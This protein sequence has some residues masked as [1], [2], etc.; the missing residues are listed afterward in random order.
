MHEKLL[1]TVTNLGNPNVL[2]V[3][4]FM[5]DVYIYGDALRI[6]PEAPVPVLKVKETSYSLGGAGSVVNDLSVLGANA[7]CLGVLGNDEHGKKLLELLNKTRSDIEGL[8]PI[9]D[10]PT[11]TKQRLVGLAQ[12]RHKQQLMRMDHEL[13]EP[14]KEKEYKQLMAVYEKKVQET[15]IVCLQDYNKGIFTKEICGKMISIAKKYKKRVLVDPSLTSDYSKYVGASLLTP[16]RQETSNTAGFEI[17]SEEDARKA[18]RELTKELQLEG[19]IITL[20]K[21]GAYLKIGE[22]EELVPTRERT[23]YDVTGAGDMVL[24][25]LAMMLASG[26]DHKTAVQI[27]NI[28]GGIEVEKFGVATVTVDEIINEIVSEY[29]GKYGKV[30]DIETLKDTIQW[31]RKKGDKIVFTNGCFD[32]LHRG[33]VEYLNFCKKQGDIVVLGLNSDSSV[34]QLKGADRPINN[35]DDRAAVLASLEAIDYITIFDDLDPY[36]TIKEVQPDYLV[37]GEDWRHKGVIGRDIVEARGGKVI[38][39][40]LVEGKSTTGTINKMKEMD[41]NK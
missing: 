9:K 17:K 10:R 38:L 4:D 28:A 24:A 40:K 31:H 22:Q 6:S 41:Q 8:I 21:E 35:Q 14:L 32:V 33:H 39:A 11:I 13:T 16:N 37:K 5:L 20:D 12:H 7:V 3:G 2:V 1:K 19:I 23:V 25:A 36:N 34:K 15:D 30:L 29:S 18:A 26:C 27:A